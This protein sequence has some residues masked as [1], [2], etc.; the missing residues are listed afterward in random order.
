[1]RQMISVQAETAW[2]RIPATGGYVGVDADFA[3]FAFTQALGIS[4]YPYLGGFVEP[5]NIPLDYYARLRGAR[6]LPSIV[7]EGGWSSA[8]AG[9]TWFS[10]AQQARYI[11]RQ[12]LL[13]QRANTIAVFQLTF[14]DLDLTAWPTS[15][16]PFAHLGLV[17][18]VLSPKPSLGAWDSLLARPLNDP[19]RPVRPFARAAALRGPR[20]SLQ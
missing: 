8:P 11:R 13:L 4:S 10:P 16:E 1:M 6:A 19:T 17:D 18:S 2:G 3:D 9:G 15:L 20:A 14:T 5:E 12:A 7:T